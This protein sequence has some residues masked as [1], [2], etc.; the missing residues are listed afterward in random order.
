MTISG[1]VRLP[2]AA[3]LRNARPLE[4]V[5]SW[6]DFIALTL[7]QL[8]ARS[9]FGIPGG[10]IADLFQ[11]FSRSK[12]IRTVL[13]QHEAGAAFAAMGH[14]LY[15]PTGA[16]GVCFGTSGPG[17]TNLITGVAAAH[18]ERVPI[19]VITGNVSTDVLGKGAVQ[20]SFHTGIDGLRMLESVVCASVSLTGHEDPSK[21]VTEL[22]QKALKERLPV[23]LNIPAN[24][25]RK[26]ESFRS[27]API[28]K[29]KSSTGSPATNES[30][31]A[32]FLSSERPMI[33]AGNGVKTARASA[34]LK[35]VAELHSVPVVVSSHGKGAFSEESPCF[36]G[37]FGVASPRFGREFWERYSPTAILYLGTALGECS[38]N[39][40]SSLP[41]QAELKIHVDLDT[42]RMNSMYKM[43]V[44]IQADLRHFLQEMAES[45]PLR[46]SS[47]LPERRVR[48]DSSGAA[49]Q[50]GKVNPS[51][52]MDALEF[53]LPQD[54]VLFSD[55]GNS[56]LWAINCLSLT[57][58]QEFYVPMGFG[59]MGSGIG[60]AIG[61]KAALPNRP[62]VCL[63]GDCA[64]LMSGAELFTARNHGIG[65]KLIVLNDGGHGTVD[66]GFAMLG[67]T[68]FQ[69]RFSQPVSFSHYATALGVRSYSVKS[70]AELL[71]LP[72]GEI[73]S[74][75]EPVLLEVL[76]DP[77]IRPPLGSRVRGLGIPGITE[78]QSVQKSAH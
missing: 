43:D 41:G 35:Q 3:L 47:Q 75:A 30:V 54:A 48:E 16:L 56:M 12:E 68:D 6:S 67:L 7:A 57:A 73:L 62:V 37:T 77:A 52:L 2:E 13:C 11:A 17:L 29:E 65:I 45:S 5:Q 50:P 34:L 36:Q 55:I 26:R 27:S 61:A 32:R 33:F 15:S 46:N 58:E 4:P 28:E 9:A 42:S 59:S 76:I 22:Y 8:G 25:G 10:P 44:S 63:A 49:I 74:S 24:V 78:S 14:T 21:V 72:L 53:S 64:S 66:H 71:A 18:Q 51:A 20:D 1:E 60:A 38:S 23:H 31:I 40:W 39:A 70:N 69:V 19:F